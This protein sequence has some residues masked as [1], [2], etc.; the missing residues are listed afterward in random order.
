MS[1]LFPSAAHPAMSRVVVLSKNGWNAY[2]RALDQRPIVTKSLTAAAGFA[3]GDII[4]QHSTKHPGERYNYLRTARMTAFG[5]F[6]AGPLQG[7]YWYGWLDKTILPLRP[8]SL[9][10]VV[11]KIG[12]D[13]TIMAPLGTVAFFSTMKTMELK[14]SE[15]LQVVKEKTWPTVAAGWQLWIPAHAINFGFIAPSMRVLYVNVVAALASAL[16]YV[17][18]GT[19]GLLCAL[20]SIMAATLYVLVFVLASAGVIAGV[21]TGLLAFSFFGLACIASFAATS[22]GIGYGSLASAQAVLRFFSAHLLPKPQDPFDM[23]ELNL[24]PVATPR[25][26]VAPDPAPAVSP[27]STQASLPCPVTPGSV[28]VAQVYTP[29]ALDP[30]VEDAQLE[31][32]VQEQI[33]NAQAVIGDAEENGEVAEAKPVLPTILASDEQSLRS[34]HAPVKANGTHKTSKHHQAHSNVKGI[35]A[36]AGG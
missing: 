23:P 3:L 2:C 5:L 16:L 14:P 9:G 15:S 26:P 24:R 22:A 8:K 6:F 19:A 11:S 28:S 35:S 7:H 17:S 25:A 36:K 34:I 30:I 4:A 31:A 32:A 13:Q 27:S 1:P 29:D 12:I 18:A 33:A 20:L 10:A 21:I